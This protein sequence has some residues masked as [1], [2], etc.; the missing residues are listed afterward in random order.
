[1]ALENLLLE[2]NERFEKLRKGY[3][4]LK[5]IENAKKYKSGH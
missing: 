5:L 1:M 4:S 3:V 2:Q